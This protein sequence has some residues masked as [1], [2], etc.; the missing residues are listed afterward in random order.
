MRDSAHAEKYIIVTISYV[1]VSKTN[2]RVN[3][4]N[5]LVFTVRAPKG[6]GYTGLL[7]YLIVVCMQRPSEIM[8]YF[9]IKCEIDHPT[10]ASGLNTGVN[11]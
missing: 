4:I 5:H 3:A 10:I 6:N 9:V 8:I 11:G 2:H 7:L 1:Y